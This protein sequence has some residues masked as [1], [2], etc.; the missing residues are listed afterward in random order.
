MYRGYFKKSLSLSMS[1]FL[2]LATV[3]SFLSPISRTVLAKDDSLIGN[4]FCDVLPGQTGNE[5]IKGVYKLLTTDEKYFLTRSISVY[6]GGVE[7]VDYGFLYINA[8]LQLGNKQSFKEVNEA[9]LGYKLNTSTVGAENRKLSEEEIKNYNKGVKVNPYDRFGFAGLSFTGYNGE[10][11]YYEVDPC[12]NSK[13]SDPKTGVFYEGRLEPKS[14]WSDIGNS[15]DPR[16]K[17]FPYEYSASYTPALGNG[18]SNF[19]F[20][21]SKFTVAFGL[22]LLNLSMSDV[23]SMIGL[24]EFLGVDGGIFQGLYKGVFQPLITT[25]II[26]SIFYL[27]YLA[28]R[29]NNEVIKNFVRILATFFL[30]IFVSFYPAV[31]IELPNT[32]ATVGQSLLVSS[33]SSSESIGDGICSTDV[34]SLREVSDK[35]DFDKDSLSE[36]NKIM[37]KSVIDLK[38]NIG[39]K[40]WHSL[41]LEPW[42]QGQFGESW[43][44]LYAKGYAP[45]G[46]AKEINN[47]NE[48]VVGDAEVPL[49]GGEKINNWAIYQISTLTNA[50]HSAKGDERPEIVNGVS[51]D[52]WRIVDALSNYDEEKIKTPI[53]NNSEV[54]FLTTKVKDNK[55]LPQWETWTGGSPGYR[56]W[57]SFASMFMAI[58]LLLAPILFGIKAVVVS[59]GLP[60]LGS[61]LPIFLLIGCYPGSGFAILEE[62]LKTIVNTMLMKIGYGFLLVLSLIV[63]GNALV[64]TGDYFTSILIAVVSSYA[65][66][67]ASEKIISMFKIY[68]DGSISNSIAKATGFIKEGVKETGKLSVAGISGAVGAKANGISAVEGLKSGLKNEIKLASYRHD[69]PLMAKARMTYHA[70]IANQSGVMK[71]AS[72]L[73]SI[74]GTKIELEEQSNGDMIF[75]GGMDEK[76]ELICNRCVQDE[77]TDALEIRYY[78]NENENKLQKLDEERKKTFKKFYSNSFKGESKIEEKHFENLSQSLGTEEFDEKMFDLLDQVKLEI[79]HYYNEDPEATPEVPEEL[80]PYLDKNALLLAWNIGKRDYVSA[81]Y[82]TSIIRYIKEELGEE[83]EISS[84]EA[85]AYIMHGDMGAENADVPDNPF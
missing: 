82:A 51:A 28:I 73:C 40:I 46:K 18:V 66:Y 63:V 54:T 30:A 13:P 58:F 31:A 22:A 65:L 36:I 52:W 53:E 24:T 16:T 48:K 43:E 76:G 72:S 7:D 84:G 70:N 83:V 55:P 35:T 26:F 37:N 1:I 78:R 67:K 32:I 29:R 5:E 47:L 10:W 80:A 57:V 39:C 17:Q 33:L 64:L 74:C 60:L 38:S 23:P 68:G 25:V 77:G 20:T 2:I 3:M 11:K 81:I 8:L 6:G 27:L 9:I 19:F 12:S 44:N 34:S 45:K 59:I 61:L 41:L 71:G 62:Y 21:I 75:N 42:S 4:L 79:N 50:H 85:T 56:L 14:T 15:Q 69:N 49:G